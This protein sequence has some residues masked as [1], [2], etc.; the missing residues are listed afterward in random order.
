MELAGFAS[1]GRTRHRRYPLCDALVEARHDVGRRR[2]I[3]LE[4]VADD[5]SFA[6]V[7][8]YGGYTTNLPLE[9]LID[10]A[11]DRIP[12]RRR[13]LG[14]EHGLARLPSRTCIWKSAKRVR[15]ITLLDQTSRVLETCNQSTETRGRSSGIRATEVA[16]RHGRGASR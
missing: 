2:S 7:R 5:A 12:L 8:C 3:L 9:D 11:V 16:C 6:L 1:V 4:G 14:P 15:G 13:D 10:G